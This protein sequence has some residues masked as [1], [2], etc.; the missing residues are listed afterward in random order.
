M[1]LLEED[2]QGELRTLLDKI[3]SIYYKSL[4]RF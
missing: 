1:P 4:V 2:R 3:T